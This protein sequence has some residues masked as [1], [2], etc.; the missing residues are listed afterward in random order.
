MPERET[1]TK[2]VTRRAFDEPWILGIAATVA[3]FGY[4]CTKLYAGN[5]KA[6]QYGFRARVAFQG[7]TMMTVLWYAYDRAQQPRERVQ[8]IREIDWDKLEEENEKLK[9]NDKS[10]YLKDM[11]NEMREKKKQNSIF[12]ADPEPSSSTSSST[13][14]KK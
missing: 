9:Q 11:V 6:S 10:A 12:A 14:Q 1:V 13:P 8:V 2:K 4:A 3:A 5:A 7:L